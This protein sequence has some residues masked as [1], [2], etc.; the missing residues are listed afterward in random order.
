VPP[1]LFG[2]G[3]ACGQARGYEYTL[4][5][6]MMVFGIFSTLYRCNTVEFVASFLPEHRN[7]WPAESDV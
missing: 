2:E 6:L 5:M 7:N 1:P 3:F 4:R